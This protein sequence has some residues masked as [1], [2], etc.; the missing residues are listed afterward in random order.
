[1]NLELKKL[2]D[3]LQLICDQHAPYEETLKHFFPREYAINHQEVYLQFY[4]AFIESI[5]WK[6]IIEQKRIAVNNKCENCHKQEDGLWIAYRRRGKNRFH[7]SLR[8]ICALCQDCK[9]LVNSMSMGQNNKTTPPTTK[10]V[11][12]QT[13]RYQLITFIN[14]HK[15]EWIENPKSIKHILEFVN[16]ETGISPIT[17][18]NLEPVLIAAGITTVRHNQSQRKNIHALTLRLFETL[19]E[20]PTDEQTQ[21]LETYRNAIK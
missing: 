18:S 17:Q 10:R 4:N 13:E 14:Q 21:L 8:D 6:Q 1:M 9:N 5:Y 19:I 2:N 11:L 16:S 12:N 7:P 15:E 3:A 20:S